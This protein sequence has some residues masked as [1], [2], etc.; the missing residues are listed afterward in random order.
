[1]EDMGESF[2]SIQ[3]ISA[4]EVS[5]EYYSMM[6]VMF[7]NAAL[8]NKNNKNFDSF[9]CPD[10]EML[11]TEFLNKCFVLPVSEALIDLIVRMEW[12]NNKSQPSLSHKIVHDAILRLESTL[13]NTSA[14]EIVGAGDDEHPSGP[15]NPVS[16]FEIYLLEEAVP[17]YV[18]LIV[19]GSK[20]DIMFFPLTSEP[21]GNVTEKWR[22][23]EKLATL[24]ITTYCTTY[25]EKLSE[26]IKKKLQT[27][28]SDWLRKELQKVK[29]TGKNS[30]LKDMQVLTNLLHDLTDHVIVAADV[31][32]ADGLLFSRSQCSYFDTIAETLETKLYPVIEQTTCHLDSYHNSHKSFHVNLRESSML[33]HT[34][35]VALKNL[36]QQLV[37]Q[38]KRKS[39]FE[40]MRNFHGLFGNAF[41]HLLHVLKAECHFRI[42]R[43]V[44]PENQDDVIEDRKIFSSTVIVLNCL[45]TVLDEWRSLEIEDAELRIAFLVKITDTICD[46]A[47]IFAEA[48]DQRIG[49]MNFQL[50]DPNHLR[51][52]CLVINSIEHVRTYLLPL[53]DMMKWEDVLPNVEEP[54]SVP[55]VK[56]QI[57]SLLYHMHESMDVQ[58]KSIISKVVQVLVTHI[59]NSCEKFVNPWVQNVSSSHNVA[60]LLSSLY[61]YLSVIH[62]VIRELIFSQLL[63]SLWLS[64]LNYIN[65]KFQ[66]GQRAEYARNIKQNTEELHEYFLH[67]EMKENAETIQRLQ[68]VLT[69]LDLNAKS[70]VELQL[71]YYG[72]LADLLISPVEYLGHLAFQA[73]YRKTQR[74]AVDVLVKVQK[75]QKIPVRKYEI[76]ELTVT[77]ELCPNSIFPAQHPV[78][79]QPVL[80][81]V[82]NP[83]FNQMFEFPHLHESVLS[84]RGA[85]IQLRVQNQ[86][87]SFC[88]EA[89]LNLNQVQNMS[90]VTSIEFLPV[91]L[92]A[93][94]TFDRSQPSFQVLESRSKWD[95][96]AKSFVSKR[97][98]VTKSR[99][100]FK[101]CVPGRSSS[102]CGVF[103]S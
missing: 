14:W 53:A 81:Q 65:E 80:E 83:V 61:D 101:S 76:D 6:K 56:Q 33:C 22:I 27:E 24:N 50:K 20:D 73:G 70:T 31:T 103:G 49:N 26:S 69:S 15:T 10:D 94:R 51:K 68:E 12:H 16:E 79:T 4:G 95:R 25:R 62:D 38:V 85:V 75:G 40:K 72:Q 9:F 17:T 102:M 47:K 32:G 91:Y 77:V 86:D 19:N 88:A 3:L 11:R 58:L 55:S 54:E 7:Q 44:I 5:E 48:M 45:C 71:D 34:F 67:L 52:V 39:S 18:D 21:K 100:V 28:L 98:K 35:Y 92:M 36:V 30:V 93:L 1:M 84:I 41:V 59:R 97:L 89:V 46:G 29:G 82:D 66:E 13:K 87:S 90:N 78:K 23:L 74:N 57:Q 37:D 64:L 63:C 43:A 42:T 2:D 99:R 96:R 60:K 8:L